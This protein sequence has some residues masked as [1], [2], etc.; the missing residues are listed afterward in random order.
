MDKKDLQLDTQI[1]LKNFYLLKNYNFNLPFNQNPLTN[2][3]N[4][5]KDLINFHNPNYINENNCICNKIYLDIPNII[6][7]KKINCLKIFNYS[8]KI[9]SGTANG[10]ILSYDLIQNNFIKYSPNKISSIISIKFN[11]QENYMLVGD[12]AGRIIYFMNSDLGFQQK[13]ELKGHN[14]REAVT[15][16]SFSPSDTK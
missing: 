10:N 3:Y 1:L 11:Q 16:I 9:V 15:D 6:D 14:I 13:Y 4:I 2:L 12:N 7:R 5:K 8:K